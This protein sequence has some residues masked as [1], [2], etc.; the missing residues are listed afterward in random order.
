MASD[1]FLLFKTAQAEFRAW[2]VLSSN[3]KEHVFPIVELTRGR[4]IPKSGKDINNR[5]T[6]PT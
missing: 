1:Y 2:D 5:F 4:K 3:A 6:Q